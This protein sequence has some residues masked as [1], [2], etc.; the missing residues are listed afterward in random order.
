MSQV[1]WY[2]EGLEVS[3]CNCDYAGPTSASNRGWFP[4]RARIQRP[5]HQESVDR[6]RASRPHQPAEWN[7]IRPRRDRQWYDKND[8]FNRPRPQGLVLS[9]QWNTPVRR[10][11]DPLKTE[12]TR[13]SRLPRLASRVASKCEPSRARQPSLARDPTRA[14]AGKSS[15]RAVAIA[16][17][18]AKPGRSTRQRGHALTA[19][20]AACP[21]RMLQSVL[22][23][24]SG[25][26][27][28]AAAPHRALI[29]SLPATDAD[30]RSSQCER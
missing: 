24:A 30:T 3:N 7:R 9:L 15:E 19:K 18:F 20:L 5:S 29:V 4:C 28:V 13:V 23:R 26:E 10:R 27:V 14:P 21:R 2:I 6:G 17:T 22:Y 1:D 12:S 16:P 8:G 25:N 11:R